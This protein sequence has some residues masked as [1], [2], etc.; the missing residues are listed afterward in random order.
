M[1]GK[2]TTKER[3]QEKLQKKEEALK[4][5]ETAKNAETNKMPDVRNKMAL[6]IMIKN[7]E[8]RIEISFDSV[9][10]LCDTFI[11]LDTGSTDRTI[12]ICRDYCKRNNIRLFLKEE[13]FVNFCVSRNVLLDYSDEVLINKDGKADKRYLILL[14]CNDELKSQKELAQFVQTHNGPQTGFHLKQ[15]WWTGNSLDSYF[16]IRMVISHNGWRYNGVVHEY[17]AK[18]NK[19]SDQ[20]DII[21]LDN[22]ILYQDRT[23]DDD[24]S[25]KRFARDKDLLYHEHIRDPTEPRTLFYLAQTCSCLGQLSEAY[26][27]YMLRTKLTGFVEEVYHAYAR[28]AEIAQT[29]GHPWE[30]SLVLFLKAYAHSQRV[31]PL[32]K[33]A[34][35]YLHKNDFTNDKPDYFIAYSYLNLACGLIYPHNQILFIDRNAYD[36]KRW[37]MMGICAYYVNRFKEGKNACIKALQCRDEKIDMDNL[38]FYLRKDRELMEGKGMHTTHLLPISCDMGELSPQDQG[39]QPKLT[40]DQVLKKAYALLK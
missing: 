30:E 35:Y 31:E 13:P 39:I 6:A 16:N 18:I 23:V 27:Y 22:I 37:H 29:L 28:M 38:L 15:N 10:E 21:R 34:D 12:E 2:K 26:Q 14:D 40:A 33:I 11:V 24:K 8:K 32:L 4:P 17:I 20:H 25:Q 7:E 36:Y 3:L 9:K 19:T 5:N 1:G